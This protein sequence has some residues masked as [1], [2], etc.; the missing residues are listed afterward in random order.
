MRQA[1]RGVVDD[2]GGRLGL[3]SQLERAVGAV[4]GRHHA[5]QMQEVDALRRELADHRAALVAEMV[6]L[7]A[8]TVEEIRTAAEMCTDQ[9]R[10]LELRARRDLVFAGEAEAARESA[11]FARR[12]LAGARTF[13]QPRATLE[14]ALSI[15]PHGGMALEFGVH[16][17]GTLR[18]IAEARG[19]VRV[20]GFD[21]FDGLPE[22]WRPGFPAGTFAAPAAPDVPGAEIVP[23]WFDDV[24]PGF[25]GGHPGPVD[26][27]HVDADLY[28]SAASVL[29]HV[30]PRLQPGSV[31]VFDEFFNYPGWQEHE[32]RAWVEFVDHDQVDFRYEAYTFDNEQVVVV[33]T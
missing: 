16:T 33:I 31:V 3:R 28:S 25:L 1:V 17:G 6:A 24:L 10:G 15:A 22:H 11:D 32:H 18:V 26:F 2:L 7:R 29:H 23:G 8:Q 5:L 27:L 20:H 9:V 13:G 30:G 19:G 12:H 4:L 14:H 21:S